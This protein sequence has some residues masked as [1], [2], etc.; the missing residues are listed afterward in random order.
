MSDTEGVKRERKRKTSDYEK[1][2]SRFSSR[3]EE[4]Y[5]AQKASGRGITS[6][7]TRCSS[8]NDF[9]LEE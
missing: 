1:L 9:L 4:L 7:K 8:D 5:E 2:Y 3:I 6:Q